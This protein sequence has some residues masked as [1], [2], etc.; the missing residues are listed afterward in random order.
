[1]NPLENFRI[2]ARALR[3]NKLRS[4]L[5]VLG[6]VIGVAGA[7]ALASVIQ[8]LLYKIPP[9]DPMTYVAVCVTL[10]AVALLASYIP[11][12]RATKVDPMFALRYE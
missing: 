8:S 10:G 4:M 6:I 7:L 11:A 1:M 9:R 2:A 3:V 12:L 5:T